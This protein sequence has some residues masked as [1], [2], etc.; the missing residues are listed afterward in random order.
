MEYICRKLSMAYENG[1]MYER[2]LKEQGR[3][4]SRNL[5]IPYPQNPEDA[6]RITDDLDEALMR[7]R[8]QEMS[9]APMY[10]NP[11]ERIVYRDSLPPQIPTNK[12][13]LI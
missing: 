11:P 7:L 10:M 1:S 4:R 5:G 8:R 6:R 2:M 3:G 13:L 9:Y 12:K